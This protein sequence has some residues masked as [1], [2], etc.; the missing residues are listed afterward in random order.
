MALKTGRTD[1]KMLLRQ[2]MK[3]IGYIC[4]LS[5]LFTTDNLVCSQKH[6]EKELKKHRR[7]QLSAL[8]ESQNDLQ[9]AHPQ[10]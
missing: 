10:R 4:C 1:L 6:T 5:S 9:D 8:Q 2:N 3:L 7:A